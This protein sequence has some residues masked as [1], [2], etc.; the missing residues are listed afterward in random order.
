VAL[1]ALMPVAGGAMY[2]SAVNEASSQDSTVVRKLLI[3]LCRPMITDTATISEAMAIAVREMA[4]TTPRAERRPT[5][6]ARRSSRGCSAPMSPIVAI[7]EASASP[8]ST[9]K[10]PPRFTTSA[11]ESSSMAAP[12]AS[13]TR[14]ASATRG[15]SQRTRCSPAE[16]RSAVIGGMLVAS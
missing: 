9:K 15:N 8:I 3:M 1:L 7:G 12:T 4:L 13:M 2:T 16:R 14:P 5:R 11:R 6:P 10:I